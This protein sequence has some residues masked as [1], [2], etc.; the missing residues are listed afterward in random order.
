VPEALQIGCRLNR[1][2]ERWEQIGGAN[3]IA[4]GLQPEWTAGPPPPQL[5]Q[6]QNKRL[7]QK[8]HRL[9]GE[10]VEE[11]L[12]LGVI[13]RI[14]P[15]EAKWISPV[16]VLEK[17]DGKM[18][19]IVDCQALNKFIRTE[20]F[21]M[22]THVLIPFLLQRGWYATKADIK[23]AY[24]HVAVCAEL[25]RMLCFT[26]ETWTYS[27]V[28]M[29]F[30][31][32]SAPRTFSRIMQCCVS[33]IRQRWR[34]TV[35]FYLDDLLFLHQDPAY[36]QRATVQILRFLTFLGWVINTKKCNLVPTPTF[37]HLGWEFDST[38]MTVRL[39]RQKKLARL[40]MVRQ[41]IRLCSNNSN[42]SARYLAKLIG[43]LQST[44]FQHSQA[45]LFLH[46]LD[47]LKR[48]MQV[49]GWDARAPMQ[50]EAVLAELAWWKT[51]LAANAPRS[52]ATLAPQASLWTDA[53]PIGWGAHVTLEGSSESLLMQG[54]WR[55]KRT[56]NGWE[57][58]AVE[59]A[60]RRMRQ[61]YPASRSLKAI[62][63]R[64]DNTATVFNINRRQ[65]CDSL[66]QPLHSLLSYADRIGV[67]LRAQHVPGIDNGHA[68][69][70]S[71]IS[72]SG[73]YSLSP[74]VLER[75]QQEWKVQIDA[76]LFASASNKKHQTY[77][78]LKRDRNA[79]ARD[80][81]TIR[82]SQFRL[83]LLHP[84]I[85]L[86]PRVLTRLRAERMRAV[87][88]A[89]AWG[90]QVW[91]NGLNGIVS[92]HTTLGPTSQ[93][94]TA[95]LSTSRRGCRLPPFDVG[96]WLLDTRMTPAKPT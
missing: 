7:P 55:K 34:V 64:S 51:T 71:R 41:A 8:M 12:A 53:S 17:K 68:D 30:G 63:V 50:G 78:T 20:S 85:P 75:L 69:A 49:R 19:K 40:A 18:R 46:A 86:L 4:A 44:K 39:P 27:Y 5:Q 72:P 10:A 91:S 74:E 38:E 14:D 82:W 83:P 90:H 24:H 43:K 11:E 45:S 80:A 2:Q 62:T 61:V 13:I 47:R 58:A 33:A 96:A 26:W 93:I 52:I 32:K 23:S 79:I 6:P 73:D 94:L 22:E 37:E 70:L 84:P 59:K 36:L 21:K 66:L 56:S 31:I 87:L 1:F 28:A 60:L 57:T 89:P 3:L 42:V 65:A 67:Q 81:F 15:S 54:V 77:C 9:V 48:Q 35:T 29:P 76:D 25:Q 95:G 88:I 16:F 92:E